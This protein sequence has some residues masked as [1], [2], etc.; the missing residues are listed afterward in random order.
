[1]EMLDEEVAPARAAAKKGAH[2][3]ERTR[4]DLTA[5]GCARRSAPAACWLVFNERHDASPAQTGPISLW[6][7]RLH[8]RC[9]TLPIPP[10]ARGRST[11]LAS[12]SE[13]KVVGW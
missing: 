13:A 1:M 7:R 8:I 5:L 6:A 3:L 9:G 12:R 2:L 4:I 11:T 10:P